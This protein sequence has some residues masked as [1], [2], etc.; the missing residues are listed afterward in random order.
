VS[1]YTG[2]DNLEVLTAARRYNAF[3]V[4]EVVAA[5]RDASR[6]LDFGAGIGTFALAMRDQGVEVECV[7]PDDVLRERLEA[8]WLRTYPSLGPVADAS[9]GYIYSL[10]VLEH[11]EDDAAT[12]GD[13][14]ARLRPGGTLFLYVPAF[15]VLFSSMDRKVGHVRRY[16]KGGLCALLASAGFTVERTEYVDSL[17]F[18]ASLVYK[19]VGSRSGDLSEGSVRFYDSV[20]FPVS[21]ALDMVL[22]R[23]LGKN[24]LVVA[25]R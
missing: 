17:G 23:F 10:N 3:L 14:Y 9:V 12:V 15:Q 7:E 21:R 25:R 24:L 22:R 2:V 16:R 11:I 19:V 1:D 13:L 4:G 5:G 18:A 20:V 6:A 8:A